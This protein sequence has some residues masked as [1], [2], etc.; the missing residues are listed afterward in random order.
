MLKKLLQRRLV[1]FG[2]GHD[3]HLIGGL[4]AVEEMTWIEARIGAHQLGQRPGERAVL[5]RMAAKT[6]LD[7]LNRGNG[8]SRPSGAERP[9]GSATTGSL[10][11]G[12]PGPL[13]IRR[14]I[15]VEGLTLVA[16]APAKHIAQ[17]DEDDDCEHQKQQS[18]DIEG[19][20]HPYRHPR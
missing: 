15:R 2:E 8:A 16:R 20:T 5:R 12:A 17:P 14:R 19:F 18:I 4:G 9:R 13:L 3:D 11:F 10:V 6:C 7:I 1:S